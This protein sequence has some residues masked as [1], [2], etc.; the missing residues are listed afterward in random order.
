MDKN[1]LYTPLNRHD[2]TEILLKMA[3]NTITLTP[4]IYLHSRGQRK[5]EEDGGG[6]RGDKSK[7]LASKNDIPTYFK[8]NY[9]SDFFK[10]VFCK[11][12]PDVYL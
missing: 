11:G 12:W 6:G 4:P 2:I 10:P 7:P 9:K 1:C 8:K 5:D 3:L